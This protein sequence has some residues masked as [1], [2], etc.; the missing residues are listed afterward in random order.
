MINGLILSVSTIGPSHSVVDPM[1]L[2][3]P[4]NLISSKSIYGNKSIKSIV[5]ENMSQ[6]AK[7]DCKIF[8]K[9][10]LKFFVILGPVAFLDANCFFVAYRREAPIADSFFMRGARTVVSKCA[11]TPQNLRHPA[12]DRK[13]DRPSE[14][15]NSIVRIQ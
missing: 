9:T 8:T 13:C 6:V 5:I 10:N 4:L 15:S 14:E 7:L 3:S 12:N 11:Q 1:W 2:P